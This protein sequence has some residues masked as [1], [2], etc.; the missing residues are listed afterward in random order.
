MRWSVV[1]M[2]GTADGEF[3]EFVLPPLSPGG[4]CQGTCGKKNSRQNATPNSRNTPR[5]KS[6]GPLLFMGIP[7]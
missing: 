5:K 1:A 7:P 3:T 6:T 4:Q 2:P